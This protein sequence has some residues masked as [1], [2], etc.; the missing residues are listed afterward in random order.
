[1][2]RDWYRRYPDN[3]LVE[4]A[5]LSLDEKGAFSLIVD[6]IYST[7]RPVD[8]NPQTI[9]RLCGCSTYR[10][11]RIRERLLA[12]GKIE[13]VEGVLDAPLV[14]KWA[15]WSGRETIPL[16]VRRAVFERDGEKC[17]YCGS[18]TGP[19]HLDHVVP[20]VQGGHS[21]ADNLVVACAPCNLSK[22]GK[23]PSEWVA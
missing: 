11:K 12:T 19:F 1:M 10:W 20:V 23:T 9:A 21:R 17:V 15:S 16:H 2:K 18:E 13:A 3:F 8:D 14:H 5:E 6:L 4:A 22:G 7:R